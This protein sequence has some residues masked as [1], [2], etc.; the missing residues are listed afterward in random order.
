MLI[1]AL[2]LDGQV[3]KSNTVTVE[4][5]TGGNR[6]DVQAA[7]L[8]LDDAPVITDRAVD[9]RYTFEGLKPGRHRLRIWGVRQDGTAVEGTVRHLEFYIEGARIAAVQ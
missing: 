6:D 9:G 2:P 5:Y 3:F 7:H 4:Y 8:Q 1:V